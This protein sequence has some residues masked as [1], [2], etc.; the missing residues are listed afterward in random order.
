MKNSHTVFLVIIVIS[1]VITRLWYFR[2]IPDP[3][4]APDTYGYY[5][6]GN[7]MLAPLFEYPHAQVTGFTESFLAYFI[8]NQ[9]TPLTTISSLCRIFQRTHTKHI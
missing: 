2:L 4:I 6:L 9:R 8:D 3:I 1:A 5:L 7:R